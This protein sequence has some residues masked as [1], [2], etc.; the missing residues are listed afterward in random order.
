MIVNIIPGPEFVRCFKRLRKKYHSLI[1]DLIVLK[2]EMT[3]NPLI[4]TDL[5][6]GVR[7]V[8]MP[9]SDKVKGKSGGARV[10]TLNVFIKQDPED[11]M[12]ITLLTIY[13][14]N[15]ISNVSDSFISYLIK[16]L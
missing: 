3:A 11:V 9:I 8:R 2:E 4:G 7:K 1:D 14:N 10:I 16:N 13:D 15:E 6:N 12:N 5:G